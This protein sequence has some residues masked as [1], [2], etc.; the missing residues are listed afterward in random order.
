MQGVRELVTED[1]EADDENDREERHA[2]EIVDE[3]VSLHVG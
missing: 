2:Y 3:L 1:G